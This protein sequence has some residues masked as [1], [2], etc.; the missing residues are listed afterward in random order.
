M[1]NIRNNTVSSIA[2][3]FLMGPSV[4][5]AAR[6]RYDFGS[7]R[8]SYPASTFGDYRDGYY[9]EIWTDGMDWNQNIWAVE[10]VHDEPAAILLAHFENLDDYVRFAERADL[11]QACLWHRRNQA[12]LDGA[13]GDYIYPD[14]IWPW[15]SPAPGSTD[16]PNG[17]RRFTFGHAA[18][19]E[20][21]F[22]LHTL[23]VPEY[24]LEKARR[25]QST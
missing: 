8:W 11:W 1:A 22:L 23:F 14:T 2:T 13:A 18:Q 7:E 3:R 6:K 17:L 24:I 20:V 9:A 19:P 12:W 10:F 16:E 15:L 5:E 25:P 4:I 21:A